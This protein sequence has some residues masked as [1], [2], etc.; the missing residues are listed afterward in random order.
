[1]LND[2]T[3]GTRYGSVLNPRTA[4]RLLLIGET[5]WCD[6]G[7]L[8]STIL[9]RLPVDLQKLSWLCR[10]DRDQL[11][12]LVECLDCRKASR[13]TVVDAVKTMLGEQDTPQG[14]PTSSPVEMFVASFRR[15][16]AK[17]VSALAESGGGQP[18][19]PSIVDRLRSA[20]DAELTRLRPDIAAVLDTPV[21]DNGYPAG[22]SPPDLGANMSPVGAVAG[23][24]GRG[25]P[26]GCPDVR[27]APPA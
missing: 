7:T 22:A 6:S 1:V 21:A 18:V 20:V 23:E 10:L 24:P 2:I 25:E 15:G 8:G 16:L 27:Q 26:V 19:D 3:G 4:R 5:W 17:L 13:R 14:T 12:E 9:A 11:D